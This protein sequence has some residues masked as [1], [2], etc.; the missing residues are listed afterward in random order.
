MLN[1]RVRH[2]S[3]STVLFKLQVRHLFHICKFDVQV[4]GLGAGLGAT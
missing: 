2:D 3:V 1:E 4:F